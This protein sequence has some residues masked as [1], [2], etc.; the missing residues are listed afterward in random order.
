MNV[1]ASQIPIGLE[2][3]R[4]YVWEVPVR[5]THWLIFFSIIVLAVTGLYIGHPLFSVSGT[6]RDHFVTGYFKVVHY[7]AAIVFTLAV[8]SR[9]AWMFMGNEYSRWDQFIP[10]TAERRRNLRRTILFYLFIRRDPPAAIGHN[11]LAGL[12]YCVVFSIYLAMIATGFALYSAGAG[13]DSPMRYFSFLVPLFGGL[14]NT[15]WI[16]HVGTWLL[17]AF[18]IHHVYSALLMSEVEATGLT[19]SIVSGN[20]FI[21]PEHPVRE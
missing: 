2:R 10:V 9:I 4:F 17:L 12:V 8:L 14:Q 20:K 11:G 6:A 16:H 5:A 21:N 3:E 7:Y 13:I 18:M 15:R 1:T 19:E